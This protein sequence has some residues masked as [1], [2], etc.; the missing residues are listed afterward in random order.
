MKYIF[1]LILAFFAS[2]LQA[3]QFHPT[4]VITKITVLVVYKD[5]RP[6]KTEALLMTLQPV[7]SDNA[8][9]SEIKPSST[10]SLDYHFNKKAL[11]PSQEHT[12]L[13]RNHTQNNLM[14]D[15]PNSLQI[16]KVYLKSIDDNTPI[17]DGLLLEPHDLQTYLT[18]NKQK[19][20]STAQ[21]SNSQGYLSAKSLEQWG[22]NSK[23]IMF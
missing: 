4:K 23:Q 7:N 18:T 14:T 17:D 15:V 1:V 6:P 8:E 3:S 2:S 10:R 12:E 19:N 9:Y 22:E 16:D 13:T 21:T 11:S 5:A 20:V